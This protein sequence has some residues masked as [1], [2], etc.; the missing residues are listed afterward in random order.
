MFNHNVLDRNKTF[1]ILLSTILATLIGGVVSV[2]LAATLSLSILARF[3]DKMVAYSV[4]VMLAFSLTDMLPEALE[5]GLDMEQAGWIMLS[6]PDLAL[7]F[8]RTVE[9]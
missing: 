7:S 8:V 6:F 4:G 2:L 1:M 5:L 3:A 9:R